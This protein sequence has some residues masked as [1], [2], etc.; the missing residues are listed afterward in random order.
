MIRS[1]TQSSE[2][3]TKTNKV[4]TESVTS[5]MKDKKSEQ[6][7]KREW[8]ELMGTNRDTFKRK[9]GAIRRR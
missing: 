2:N 7:S 6:L 1:G 5:G 9:N 8:S 4:D 3:D